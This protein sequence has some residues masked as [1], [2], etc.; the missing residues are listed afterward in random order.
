MSDESSSNFSVGW[1]T[2]RIGRVVFGQIG[3]GGGERGGTKIGGGG[4]VSI[5]FPHS[6][7]SDN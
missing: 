4:V 5:T 1:P 3:G 6:A 2:A 7:S